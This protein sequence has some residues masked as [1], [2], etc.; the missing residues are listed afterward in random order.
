MKTW[1]YLFVALALAATQLPGCTPP[2]T[3]TQ[4]PPVGTTD[5]VDSTDSQETTD[6]N[7]STDP[8]DS[9]DLI[10]FTDPGDSTDIVDSTDPPVPPLALGAGINS[11]MVTDDGE[12]IVSLA[13]TSRDAA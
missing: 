13:A 2:K 1:T 11:V 3:T 7:L 6:P 8:N 4:T 10:D 5:P 12:W 9:T